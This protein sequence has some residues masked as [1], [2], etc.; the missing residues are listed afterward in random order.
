MNTLSPDMVTLAGPMISGSSSG[1]GGGSGS[2]IGPTANWLQA[3][4]VVVSLSHGPVTP[5]LRRLARASAQTQQSVPVGQVI[6]GESGMIIF[7]ALLG[8]RPRLIQSGC[9]KYCQ[10]KS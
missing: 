1:T 2:T 3:F 10:R 6:G 5:S 4:P 9:A 8:T 7:N